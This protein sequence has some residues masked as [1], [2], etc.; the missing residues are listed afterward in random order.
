MIFLTPRFTQ[1][2]S[3]I[4]MVGTLIWAGMLCLQEV[5]YACNMALY[6]RTWE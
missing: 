5:V 4:N 6:Y 1:F 3:M 2:T